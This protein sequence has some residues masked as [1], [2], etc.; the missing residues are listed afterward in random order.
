[1]EW[2]GDEAPGSRGSPFEF[3]PSSP[4][5]PRHVDGGNAS[6]TVY[7]TVPSSHPHDVE[8][9]GEP[10]HQRRDASPLRDLNNQFAAALEK[11]K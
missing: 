7:Q 8:N 5:L 11:G 10:L 4:H 6:S 2:L 1:M 9:V 3:A